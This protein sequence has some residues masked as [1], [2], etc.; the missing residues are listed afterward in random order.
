MLKTFIYLIKEIKLLQLVQGI[1]KQQISI[2]VS[3]KMNQ[4][5]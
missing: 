4:V 3:R 2:S 5:R 1:L